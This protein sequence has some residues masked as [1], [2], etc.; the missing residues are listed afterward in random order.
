MILAGPGLEG[1]RRVEVPVSLVDVLPTLLEV[2]GVEPPADL[3]GRSLLGLA[4]GEPAGD[5]RALFAHRIRGS[6]PAP[7]LERPP[8][9]AVML[10]RW[11]LIHDTKGDRIE[12]F[13][14]ELDPDET[15]D[16]AVERPDEV[17]ALRELL[18]RF[19]SGSV[20]EEGAS[21][22]VDIDDELLRTLE[23]LGYAGD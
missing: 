18:D 13:D 12:L 1:P 9:W 4:R 22:E 8:L 20:L 23:E 2:A 3:A 7:L 15:R 16:L 14:L 19:I 5:E 10:G 11:K 21:V 17:A 6:T